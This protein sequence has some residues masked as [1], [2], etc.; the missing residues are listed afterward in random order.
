MGIGQA[1]AAIDNGFSKV[2]PGLLE[3]QK[4]EGM[5]MAS[6][7]RMIRLGNAVILL[8]KNGHASEA[9]PLIRE[10]IEKS[11]AMKRL[12]G[13]PAGEESELH[14]ALTSV[15]AQG[16]TEVSAG[17]PWAHIFP[18]LHRPETAPERMLA[19]AVRALRSALG[20]LETRWPGSFAAAGGA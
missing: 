12:S 11:A 8:C 6:A 2:G 17:I 10:M 7:G 19:L 1:K 9:G 13:A 14:K 18:E 20:A 4:V 15:E 16:V 5:L 3:G